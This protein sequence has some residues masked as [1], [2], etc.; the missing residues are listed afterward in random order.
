MFWLLAPLTWLGVALLPRRRWR[1][2]LSRGMARTL[3]RL[4]ATPLT[5]TGLAR[6]LPQGR[7]CVLVVNH[8]SYLDGPTLIAALPRELAFVAKEA[9]APQLIAGIFLRRLGAEFVQ[10]FDPRR[11]LADLQRIQRIG[12]SGRSLV[13]FAEG[14]FSAIPGLRPF[15]MG[16][17]VTAMEAQLPVVPVA[18][19]G[20]RGIL[21]AGSWYPHPGAITVTVGE[22]IMPPLPSADPSDNWRAALRLRDQ[23]RAHILAHCGEPDL[24]AGGDRRSPPG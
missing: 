13:F 6:L 4:T 24:A 9:L 2:T 23:A 11:G 16:A 8:A 20:T 22:A 14:T 17:F 21:R 1:F 19:A 15:R 3:A 12:Q 10:R 18:I 7:P 5:V